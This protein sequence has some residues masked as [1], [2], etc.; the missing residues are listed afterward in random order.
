[1]KP[2]PISEIFPLIEGKEFDAFVEDIRKHGMRQPL[3]MYQGKI[4]DGRNRWRA[5]QALKI[6]PKLVPYKGDDPVGFVLSLNLSRRH[7]NESQRAMIA[8][9]AAT[10]S[11][12][13]VRSKGSIDPLSSGVMGEKLSVSSPSVKRARKVLTKGSKDLVRAVEQG[14]ISVSAAA[15]LADA[16][17]EVQREATKDHGKAAPALA[18]QIEEGK[19]S[20]EPKEPPVKTLG[21]TIPPD[22]LARIE[23]EQGMVD[24]M[25]GLLAQLARLITAYEKQTLVPGKPEKEHRQTRFRDPLEMLAYAIRKSRPASV[26]P[27]C[28]CVE[29]VQEKCLACYGAGFVSEAKIDKTACVP[30]VYL[31]EGDDAIISVK[32]KEVNLLSY[33]GENF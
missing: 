3:V 8:A 18:K 16:S 30:P 14:D 1:M 7:L 12:G 19:E 21:R 23:L 33:L 10:L 17:P 28:K 31:V 24:E 20:G 25:S 15:D 5:C 27:W 9:K 13:G 32:G 11:R 2:H 26:C 22:V 4:L 6:K 29:D